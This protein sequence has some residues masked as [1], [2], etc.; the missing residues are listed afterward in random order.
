MRFFHQVDTS[1]KLYKVV[2]FVYFELNSL[3]LYIF[4]IKAQH[5]RKFYPGHFM[6]FLK[7]SHKV[8]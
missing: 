1:I 4:T 8:N 3:F 6:V 7:L 2:E 5:S